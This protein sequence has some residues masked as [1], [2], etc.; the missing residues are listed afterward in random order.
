[1]DFD[2]THSKRAGEGHG[3]SGVAAMLDQQ[4]DVRRGE[5]IE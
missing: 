5:K 1:L 4:S 2:L 3:Q